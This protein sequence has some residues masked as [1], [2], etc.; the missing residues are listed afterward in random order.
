MY[1]NWITGNSKRYSGC[2]KT[3]IA[4]FKTNIVCSEFHWLSPTLPIFCFSHF[5]NHLKLESFVCMGFPNQTTNDNRIVSCRF[6]LA[7]RNHTRAKKSQYGRKR[8]NRWDPS[9]RVWESRT[10]TLLTLT[11]W[12]V[13]NAKQRWSG[14]QKTSHSVIFMPRKGTHLSNPQ[15]CEY[16]SLVKHHT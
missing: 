13:P 12:R 4:C 3:Y 7:P 11:E 14:H 5:G 8:N 16:T 10:R 6:G 15:K 1:N 2:F 9:R